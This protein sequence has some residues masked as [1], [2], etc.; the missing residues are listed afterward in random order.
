MFMFTRGLTWTARNLGKN[1]AL[2][3]K[4]LQ[5]QPGIAIGFTSQ[6][7]DRWAPSLESLAKG[8]T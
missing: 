4:K 2:V 1:L 6:S 3:V 7:S 8:W 5:L